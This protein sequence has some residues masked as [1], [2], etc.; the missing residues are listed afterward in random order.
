MDAILEGA[1]HG[2]AVNHDAVR[3]KNKH[4]AAARAHHGLKTGAAAV[5]GHSE[6]RQGRAA[7]PRRHEH[8]EVALPEVLLER[9]EG[10][11]E[12][13]DGGVGGADEQR[14]VLAVV[15]DGVCGDEGGCGVAGGAEGEA[16]SPDDIVAD[17]V[18]ACRLRV[19]SACASEDRVSVFPAHMHAKKRPPS[20]RPSEYETL[21][22]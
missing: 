20:N 4:S 11:G 22:V 12:V 21:K 5:A 2:T 1:C 17:I 7:A 19:V 15:V 13:S 6:A 16:G 8:P 9:P 14:H 10:D 3:D 18:T